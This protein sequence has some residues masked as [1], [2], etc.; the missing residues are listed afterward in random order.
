MS[1]RNPASTANGGGLQLMQRD[2]IPDFGRMIEAVALHRDREAFACLFD[3]FAPRLKSYLLRAGATHGA[4]EDFAQEAML[5]V[6]RK[7]GL[8]DPVRAGASTWIFTIARNLRIDAARRE[9]LDRREPDAADFQNEPERPDT[10]LADR[11]EA[12]R[13]R[14]A[15]STLS[16]EQARIVRLSY[17]H[18]KAHA[19]IAQELGVPLGTVKSRLRLALIRL[20]GL[21][22][23]TA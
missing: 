21:L 4:A 13:I 19:E 5:T 8:F 10:I 2:D 11:D 15:L 3:H 20:R 18:D 6:W 12:E 7:A 14:Q 16:D 1:G 23:E 22:S 9:K 17:F